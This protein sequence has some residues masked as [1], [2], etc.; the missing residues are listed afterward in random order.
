MRVISQHGNVDLPYEQIVVCHAMESVIALHNGEKYVLGKYSS[1][2]K[3]YKAMEML[4]KAYEDNEFYH[5]MSTTNTFEK[6]VSYLSNE[7]FKEL[8]AEYFQ[9][10]QDDEIEV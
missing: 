9:F 6:A 3:A 8:T 5:Y 1:K 4:R 2:E 10:P 7:K